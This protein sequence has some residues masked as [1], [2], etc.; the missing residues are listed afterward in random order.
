MGNLTNGPSFQRSENLPLLSLPWQTATPVTRVTRLG[1]ASNW[2]REAPGGKVFLHPVPA[3]PPSGGG[4]AFQGSRT[5]S[6][7]PSWT[8]S[9]SWK[10][11]LPWPVCRWEE[12]LGSTLPAR[13]GRSLLFLAGRFL[14]P[15]PPREAAAHGMGVFVCICVGRAFGGK[16]AGSSLAAGGQRSRWRRWG[17]FLS[18]P[19]GSLSPHLRHFRYF[20]GPSGGSCPSVVPPLGAKSTWVHPTGAWAGNAPRRPGRPDSA[21]AQPRPQPGEV[22]AG[23][24]GPRGTGEGTLTG[25]KAAFSRRTRVKLQSCLWALTPWLPGSEE[26]L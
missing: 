9:V 11:A 3:T 26:I 8:W 25:G 13:E 24:P 18:L 6:L 20:L 14:P 23:R 7:L 1:T 12:F 2:V 4:L 15:P 21:P 10:P 17:Y 16:V 22:P 19:L 5:R